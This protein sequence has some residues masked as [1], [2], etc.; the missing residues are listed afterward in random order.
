MYGLASVDAGQRKVVLLMGFVAELWERDR[1]LAH[2]LLDAALDEPLLAE[3]VP[4]LHAA[5]FIDARGFERIMLA[6]DRTLV[7]VAQWRRLAYG[8]ATDLLPGLDIRTLVLR[9]SEHADGFEPA[10]EILFMR[11]HSDRSAGR[12]YEPELLDAGRE[13]LRRAAFGKGNDMADYRLAELAR[14]CLVGPEAGRVAAEVARR[15]RDAVASH[16]AYA[17]HHGR[18]VQALVAAA[19]LDVLEALFEDPD[20][21]R[22][23]LKEMFDERFSKRSSPLDNVP[24]ADLLAWCDRD[25]QARYPLAAEI[26]PF[27]RRADEAGP[28][29][30]TPLARALLES[31]PDP[32]AV[33]R[34]FVER[35]APTSWSGSRAALMEANGRL[36]DDL[37]EEISAENRAWLAD[38][39]A[40]LAQAVAEERQREREWA[41]RDERFE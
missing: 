37:D 25:P 24:A 8:R 15:L 18:F 31:A 30:W 22:W 12:A 23:A 19:P 21:H 16:E 1:P 17:F 33:L 2:E 6:M 9:I 20:A 11:L 34:V 27:A 13:L 38:A 41:R 5:V 39:R 40:Q 10:R 14:V 7:P 3:F 4:D 28:L 26:V 35:F 32:G 29:D 36:L